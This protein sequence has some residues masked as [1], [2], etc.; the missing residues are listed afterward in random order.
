MTSNQERK[1]LRAYDRIGQELMS[2][3]DLETL[4]DRLLQISREV[5]GFENAIIRLLS[6]DGEFLEAA[7]SYGYPEDAVQRRIRVGE[8]V[9]GAVARSGKPVLLEDVGLEPEYVAGIQGARSELAVPLVARDRVIG[10][11]NVESIRPGAFGQEDVV[12]LLT[13]AGQAAVAIENSRLYQSLQ[14][15]KEEFRRLHQFNTRV[16]QSANL[17]I[18]TLDESLRIT[19]WNRKMEEHSGVDEDEALGRGLF[20]L[21]PLL[22]QEGFADRVRRVL[23]TGRAEKLKLQHRNLR[24]E[25]RI[26]KRRLAPLMEEGRPVGVVVMVEDITEFK[27]LL[28][29]IVQSEKLA[30]VGK[31]TAGIAHE[32]NNPLAVISYGAQLLGREEGLSDF[33]RELIER[34]DSET[35]RLK[36]LTGGL[37]CFSRSGDSVRRWTQ[38]AEVLDDVLRLIG[39]EISRNRHRVERRF[40]AAPMILA[41]SNKLRQV[42]LNL[43]MNACQAMAPDGELELGVEP[44]GEGVCIRICDRG[45]GI[46]LPLREKIFE[47]FFTTKAQGQG[48]GLGL[49][50]CRKIVQEHGG[51]LTLE[52]RPGGGSCFQICLPRGSA[53]GN[54]DQRD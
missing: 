20:E 50:I 27:G 5:F 48:T 24:G 14:E 28:N 53:D 33:Q 26:Q 41:D 43:L 34:I 10:V 29:Q 52:E 12:P 18:Y 2:L 16:L 35:E 17:G 46:A 7:A 1:L 30:E 25:E 32:I 9:M 45:P 19:S 13:M 23:R 47:P 3:A 40:E 38:V 54:L 31:L 51:A 42:F 8:G 37:L 44:L 6:D 15:A 39:Y 21:F 11:F 4:L 36:A 22:E 49:Y